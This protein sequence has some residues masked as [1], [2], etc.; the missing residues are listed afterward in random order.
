M[1][2]MKRKEFGVNIPFVGMGGWGMDP[3]FRTIGADA[4]EGLT[5]FT[6][7]FPNKATPKEWVTRSMEQCKKEYSDEPFIA[8]ELAGPGQPYPSRIDFGTSRLRE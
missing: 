3:S 1:C 6:G 2:L 4:L 8:Q 5:A 7:N